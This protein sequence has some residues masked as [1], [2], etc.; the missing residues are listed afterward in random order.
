MDS[1]NNEKYAECQHPQICL[2]IEEH[3]RCHDMCLKKGFRLSDVKK[4]KAE[5][6]NEN[7]NISKN[8]KLTIDK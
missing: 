8:F 6:G 1:L 7:K 3:D 2:W 4:Y 5:N